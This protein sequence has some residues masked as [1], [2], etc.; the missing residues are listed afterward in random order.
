MSTVEANPIEAMKAD[1]RE[2]R[3]KDGTDYALLHKYGKTR[4]LCND[5]WVNA[6]R[7][8]AEHHGITIHSWHTY[9]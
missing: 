6:I 4:V 9:E 5:V 2:Q 1:L 3:I 8:V 7:E